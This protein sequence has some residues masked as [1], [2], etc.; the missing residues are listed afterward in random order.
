MTWNMSSSFSWSIDVAQGVREPCACP[1]QEF[2]FVLTALAR[3]V[4]RVTSRSAIADGL[5]TGLYVI[6]RALLAIPA[7]LALPNRSDTTASP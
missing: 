2:G 6:A 4:R 1:S 5:Q 7:T 3:P